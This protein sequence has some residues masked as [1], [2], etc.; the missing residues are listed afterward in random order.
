MPIYEIERFEV[1]SS[2]H[3]VQATSEDEAVVKLFEGAGESVAQSLKFIAA[4][5]D[6]GM[7]PDD[8]PTLVG[9]LRDRGL[10]SDDC[11]DFIPSIRGIALVWPRAG[12]TSPKPCTT[13][14]C[15]G[16]TA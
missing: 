2:K 16:A 9:L 10:I 4:A 12:R 11:V 8:N 3:R 6:R 14:P 15:K 5:Q 7:P 13:I 1:Y